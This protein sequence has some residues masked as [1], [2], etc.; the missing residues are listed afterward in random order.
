M[1]VGPRQTMAWQ[2]MSSYISPFC[3]FILFTSYS[4]LPLLLCWL[5]IEASLSFESGA[6]SKQQHYGEQQQQQQATRNKE[7]VTLPY[8][9]TKKRHLDQT[10]EVSNRVSNKSA[11]SCC[12]FFLLLFSVFHGLAENFI[13]KC[14]LLTLFYFPSPRALKPCF[15]YLF[16]WT[17]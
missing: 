7:Q 10:K 12:I 13:C 15:M 6:T 16:P 2:L 4:F 5:S 9:A 3:C 14:N 11:L 1:S 17:P 8:K